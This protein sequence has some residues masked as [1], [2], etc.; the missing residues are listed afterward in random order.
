M[1]VLVGEG[2][3]DAQLHTCIREEGE[4]QLDGTFK[5]RIHSFTSLHLTNFVYSRIAEQNL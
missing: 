2:Q 5:L 3:L 4:R 1:G